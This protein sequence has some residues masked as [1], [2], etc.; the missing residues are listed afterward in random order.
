MVGAIA[1]AGVSLLTHLRAPA[2]PGPAA[3]VAGKPPP[4]VAALSPGTGPTALP[5]GPAPSAGPESSCVPHESPGGATPAGALGV[6]P[7]NFAAPSEAPTD[8][9][10]SPRSSPTARGVSPGSRGSPDASSPRT[11]PPSGVDAAATARGPSSGGGPA[12][13]GPSPDGAPSDHAP[14]DHAPPGGAK[15]AV[16]IAAA[17]AT[18]LATFQ[19][20]V[21]FGARGDLRAI[22][23]ALEGGLE[24]EARRIV[25]R[26]LALSPANEAEVTGL[27]SALAER[28]PDPKARSTAVRALAERSGDASTQALSRLLRSSSAASLRPAFVDA[29]GQRADLRAVESLVEFAASEP[30]EGELKPNETRASAARALGALLLELLASRTGD[31]AETREVRKAAFAGLVRLLNPPAPRDVRSTAINHLAGSKLPEALEPL[32]KVVRNGSED[33][34][35]R[36]DAAQRLCGI[37]GEA[38]DR[39]IEELLKDPDLVRFRSSMAPHVAARN[40]PKPAVTPLD[41]PLGKALAKVRSGDLSG[42][43]EALA[44]PLDAKGRV[45]IASGL[46]RAPGED[47]PW[48]EVLNGL[49]RG[50]AEPDVRRAALRALAQRGGEA[51]RA[52]LRALLPD[53]TDEVSIRVAVSGLTARPDET[54]IAAL[55]AAATSPAAQLEHRGP[56]VPYLATEGLQSL[57][58]QETR[59]DHRQRGELSPIA[60]AALDAVD[61]LIRSTA[62]LGMRTVAILN[63]GIARIPE[64]V[65]L[66]R[67]YAADPTMPRELRFSAVSALGE[68][69]GQEARQALEDVSLASDLEELRRRAKA[70]LEKRK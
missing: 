21:E 57:V 40:A 2:A 35:L 17:T 46:A 34:F 66:L 62:R 59:A 38:T 10:P 44:G 42:V 63:L 36:S 56:D 4:P 47:A 12:T 28:D 6:V 23:A 64:V 67:S 68:V 13:R 9:R 1:T 5:P 60:R 37:P 15:P 8:P 20:A 22:Q 27:L 70:S 30:E 11:V 26:M 45:A 16:A 31:S 3:L 54:G 51:A 32:V 49:A 39:A 48:V 69:P 14:S 65:P 55:L 29:L 24:P 33:H 61:R 52:S 41:S 50:D 58:Y 19:R 53:L 43:Q 7:P 18:R 25:V